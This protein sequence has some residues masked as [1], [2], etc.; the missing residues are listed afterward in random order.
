MVAGN[1]LGALNH[2]LL[3]VRAAELA[4]L[5]VSAIVL[6]SISDRDPGVAEA[7]NFDALRQLL[8][9]HTLRRFPWVDRVD[10]LDALAVAAEA[11]GLDSLLVP[12]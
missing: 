5:T 1:R 3:T 9:S 2:V 10:D 7:T 12:A 4:G 8:P 11:A 6:T